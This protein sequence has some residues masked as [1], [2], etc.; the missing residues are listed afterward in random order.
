M[1]FD[2]KLRYYQEEGIK[3]LREALRTY[4]R[5]CFCMPTGAGKTV[6]FIYMIIR[7]LARGKTCMILT[8]RSELYEQAVKTFGDSTQEIEFLTPQ[9]R[10]VKPAKLYVG[11][12]KTF[13]NRASKNSFL[14]DVDLVII[15]EVHHGD[16]K[17]AIDLLVEESDARIIGV[18]ATP[19]T[20][21]GKKYEMK[22]LFDAIVEPVTTKELIEKG[23]L[24]PC[25]T[26]G[27]KVVT[28][29]MKKKGG[30]YEASQHASKISE[31]ALFDDVAMR[32]NTGK[33]GIAFCADSFQTAWCCVE[34]NKRGIKAKFVISKP[35]KPKEMGTDKAKDYKYIM[36][37]MEAY[38][39][40][41]E[42][43]YKQFDRGEFQVLVNCGIATTGFDQPKIENVFLLR[44]VATPSTYL[45][46]CGRGS[47]LCEAI[48]KKSF[49]IYDY[50][51]SYQELGLT[52]DADISM[53]AIF[54]NPEILKKPAGKK[55]GEKEGVLPTKECCKCHALIPSNAKYCEW[56]NARQMVIETTDGEILQVEEAELNMYDII[57]RKLTGDWQYMK[58][59][60]AEIANAIYELLGFKGL[61]VYCKKQSYKPGWAYRQETLMMSRGRRKKW[62]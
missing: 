18:T 23:F 45:Q 52:W 7:A 27:S 40:K 14:L 21:K 17:K 19:I 9:N 5:V 28:K 26:F 48:G 10:N 2:F 46:I 57:N 43:I 16:H 1:A 53:T 29:G 4:Y 30:E 33:V 38:S 32:S 11:M 35:Q 36:K 44:K 62:R 56:C 41:K 60:S 15:D 59:G 20:P 58:K 31:Y 55:E 25:T 12:T 22:D 13:F 50:F 54:N 6:T 8:H 24:L 39:G 51:K 37:A 42:E 3:E 34:L 49:T 61:I 47:R